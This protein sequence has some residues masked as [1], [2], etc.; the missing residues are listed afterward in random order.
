MLHNAIA[1]MSAMMDKMGLEELTVESS[2][3]F[4]VFRRE[5]HLSKHS[6]GV[7]PVT[8]V[9]APQPTINNQQ[10]V[11]H[12]QAEQ[13]VAALRSPMVGVAY[14]SA[15]PG[16]KPFTQLGAKVKCGDTV[17][18]IEA[19][20]T[21]NPVKADKDGVVKDILIQDGQVVEFDTP[22]IVIG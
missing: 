3:L 20:K 16:S 15:E 21:F 8:T 22:L 19:M 17:C 7:A 1:K 5:I 13:P 12:I 2:F 11:A 18:L 9:I 10:P 6:G 4:G 14:L